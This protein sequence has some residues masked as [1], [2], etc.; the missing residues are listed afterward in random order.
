[1]MNRRSFLASA[2]L[3]API[4]AKGSQAPFVLGVATYSLRK[5]SRADAIAA[6][7]KMDVHHVSIKEYHLPYVS[8]PEQIAAGRKEFESAGLKI[9]S[10]GNIDLKGD[11]AKIRKMFEYAKAAGMPTIVCAPSQETIPTVEKMVKEFNIR[12]AIHNHGPEDKFFPTPASVLEAVKGRDPRMGLCIDI[13]HTVRTGADV[14]QSIKDAGNRL[15]DMH[16]KDLK[17]LK[18]KDSQCAVGEGAMPMR[19]IFATLKKLK[20]R[21]GCMLE[22]EINADN[23]VPG[24]ITSFANMRKMLAEMPS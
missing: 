5:L 8:T 20:Y 12:V 22:Y 19:E 13:G 17:N 3:A 2:A 21:G 9:L 15:F 24:M 4:F 1:M 23:P 18:D 10:G 7:R 6:I 16:V 14:V 11:E